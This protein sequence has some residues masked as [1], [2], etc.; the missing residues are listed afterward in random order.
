MAKTF[1]SVIAEHDINGKITPL[2]IIWPDSRQ[3]SVDRI[4]DVRQAGAMKAG[5]CGTCY[6]CRIHG[7]EVYLFCNKLDGKWFIEH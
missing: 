1:V 2:K 6:I 5:G 4:L 3:F 7:K